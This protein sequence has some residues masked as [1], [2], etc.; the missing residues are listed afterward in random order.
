MLCSHCLTLRPIKRLIKMG[1]IEL[2]GAYIAQRQIPPQIPIGFCSNLSVSVSVS[3][4]V[5]GSVNAP[6]T[7][8]RD[9]KPLSTSTSNARVHSDGF[10]FVQVLSTRRSCRPWGTFRTPGSA[11]SPSATSRA[12]VPRSTSSTD[13]PLSSAPSSTTT[14]AVSWMTK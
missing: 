12:A 8:K 13:I 1:F 5:S 14:G 2:C 7:E 11:R 10:L 3:I 4:S 9:N 6:F